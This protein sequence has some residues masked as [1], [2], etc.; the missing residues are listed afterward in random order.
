MSRKYILLL[1][2]IFIIYM[3]VIAIAKDTSKSSVIMDMDTGRVL[4]EKNANEKMLIA[5]TTKIMTAILTL[6]NADITEE[7][8]IG[9]EILTMYGTNIYIEVGEKMKIID[10]LYGLLLRSGNDA[11]IALATYIGGTEENFVKMMNEKAKQLGMLNTTFEN[12]HGLD[13]DTT[14]YSTAY[15]MALLSSYANMNKT[16]QEISNTTKYTTSTKNKS[17]L[18]YNRN[19]LLTTY[20]YCTGGKNGYTPSAG[21]TLVTTAT[22]GTQNITIVTLNDQNEYETHIELYN[23]AFATY[24]NYK[25][26]DKN[27]LKLDNQNI[28]GNIYVKENFIYPLKDSEKEKITT[29]IVLLNKKEQSGKKGI[30]KI[31]LADELIG[32]VNIYEKT[33]KKEDESIFSKLKNYILET[34]KKLML[35]RQ[36]NLNPG[37]LVPIPLDTKSSVF[38]IL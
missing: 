19:K 22:K 32:K 34:L 25:I 12:S 26:I 14:N 37:P 30:I 5:S 1:V 4:Y 33:E 20:E 31:K 24:K 16:Y 10:L 28:V 3:P 11:A 7:I 9:N 21:R 27:N 23:Y 15:D 38:P 18:W 17:Y 2:I 29:E 13:D 8:I 6:E 35:G 36:N